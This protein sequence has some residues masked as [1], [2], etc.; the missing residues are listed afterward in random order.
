M[1]TARAAGLRSP[2]VAAIVLP[3][4]SVCGALLLRTLCHSADKERGVRRVRHVRHDNPEEHKLPKH[5]AAGCRKT[6][7]CPRRGA[8]VGGEA[9]G[10]KHRHGDQAHGQLYGAWCLLP[11]LLLRCQQIP[12]P[13]CDLLLLG[14]MWS[15]EN[16]PRVSTPCAVLCAGSGS[17]LCCFAA[18]SLLVGVRAG[19]CWAAT[20]QRWWIG[21]TT[22]ASYGSRRRRR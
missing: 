9:A 15:A 4:A 22:C 21:C 3:L 13:D 12:Q 8:Q 19:S 6:D 18:D 7:R 16:C 1:S 5:P 11:S 2:C 10:S 20:R 17:W 14:A